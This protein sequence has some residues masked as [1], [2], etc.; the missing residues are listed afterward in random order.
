MTFLPGGRASTSMPVREHVVGVGEDEPPL[1]AGEEPL[2]DPLELLPGVVERLGED[3]LDAL[4]DLLDD[5]EQVALGAL[6][7]LE[8]RGEEGVPLLE[9][10]ELLERER[11]DPAQGLQP[12]LGLAQP[13]L[14]LLAHVGHRLGRGVGVLPRADDVRH[15]AVRAELVDE[16]L[17]VD[18]ELLDRLGLQLLDA[19]DLAG[20]GHLVAVGGVGE[21]AQLVLHARPARR[22]APRR[23]ARARA[24]RP[25][26]RRAAWSRGPARRR[27]ARRRRP[28]RRARPRRRWPRAGGARDARAAARGRPA[29]C[30]PRPRA[31]RPGPS[32]PGPAPRGCAG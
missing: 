10:R 20:A 8:L 2:E 16:H 21:V 28:R 11:V 7:V 4:V 31:S 25:R 13:L 12:P 17:G 19:G 18:A 14:L 6:E 15:L 27:P 3:L 22:A 29:R 5:V 23:P 30:G 26:R 32:A 24:G 1:A 9:R